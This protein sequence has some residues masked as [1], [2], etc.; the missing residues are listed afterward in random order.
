M[1]R[2]LVLVG[3]AFVVLL[4]VLSS[5]SYISGELGIKKGTRT[6][7]PN[8]A[9]PMQFP[10]GSGGGGSSGSGSGGGS[11]GG[12][13]PTYTSVSFWISTGYGS[14]TF[15]GNSYTNGQSA[16]VIQGNSYSIIANVESVYAQYSFLKWVGF[17]CSFN[18]PNSPSTTVKVNGGQIDMI[19]NATSPGQDLYTQSG[20]IQ[21]GSTDYAGATFN[22]PYATYLT[23]GTVTEGFMAYTGI[24]GTAYLPGYNGPSGNTIRNSEVLAGVMGIYNGTGSAPY[25]STAILIGCQKVTSF[26]LTYPTFDYPYYDDITI[27]G[28]TAH[29]SWLV[30][31]PTT[32]NFPQNYTGHY[33]PYSYG[34]NDFLLIPSMKPVPGHSMSFGIKILSNG[35]TRVNVVD[36]TASTSCVLYINANIRPSPA[37]SSE[38]MVSPLDSYILQDLG[39]PL[40]K[41]P[42]G[43]TE[44]AM[45]GLPNLQTISFTNVASSN[46]NLIGS[47]PV[48]YTYQQMYLQM[49]SSSGN[50]FDVVPYSDNAG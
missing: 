36:N 30:T 7:G 1:D 45:L 41:Q 26:D 28:G 29:P 49:P 2:K 22:V 19:L 40:S 9:L 34:G 38:Y 11:S 21:Y 4:M 27:I 37:Y 13:G 43:D 35:T 10:T 5:M 46:G 17:G 3:A 6:Q 12:S 15:N 44:Y 23:A 32:L 42:A 25:L 24:G 31:G 8:I 20:M 14:I 48:G 18:N 39:Y 47:I 50:S 16:T 33:L